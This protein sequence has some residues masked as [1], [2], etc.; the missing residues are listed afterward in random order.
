[1]RRVIDIVSRRFAQPTT[2]VRLSAVVGLSPWHLNV[3]FHR[4]TGMTIH[5]YA[6]SLRMLRAATE[7]ARGVKIEAV[8]R[9]VGYRSRQSFYRQFKSWF[10][11]NPTVLRPDR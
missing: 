1:V 2:L 4:S 10:G 9:S 6:T 11:V 8:S 3:V 5:E 7:I